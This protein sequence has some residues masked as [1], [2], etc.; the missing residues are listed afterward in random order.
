LN[1]ITE[2]QEMFFQRLNYIQELA[3]VTAISENKKRDHLEEI[4]YSVTFDVLYGFLELIDGYA[5]DAIKVDLVD[6]ETGMSMGKNIELHDKC[7][8]Y[9]RTK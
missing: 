6:K 8:D 1:D 5:T 2:K 7:A 3:V 4:L 9:L